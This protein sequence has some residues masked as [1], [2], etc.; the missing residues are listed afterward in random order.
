MAEELSIKK[1]AVTFIAY[2]NDKKKSTITDVHLID[3][4]LIK[5]SGGITDPETKKLLSKSFDLQ[6]NHFNTENDLLEY[7]SLA[8]P[9]S[10]K[11]A[12]GSDNESLFDLSISVDLN[13]YKGLI[14]EL[15]KYL[16]IL[17]Q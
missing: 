7:V 17:T 12:Y 3:R 11:V 14:I 8:M 6:I 13:D 9:S 10:L 5:W 15:K 16:K 4:K 1:E 2:V